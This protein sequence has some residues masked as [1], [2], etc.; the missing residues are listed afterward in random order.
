MVPGSSAGLP[1]EGRGLL[2][3]RRRLPRNFTGIPWAAKLLQWR[4]NLPPNIL[5]QV[6]CR[7]KRIPDCAKLIPWMLVGVT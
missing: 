6:P 1:A 2:W 7:F 3:N 4:L 5:K